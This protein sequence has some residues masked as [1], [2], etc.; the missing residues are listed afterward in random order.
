MEPEDCVIPYKGTYILLLPLSHPFSL[1]LK[2]PAIKQNH[3]ELCFF[4]T[5]EP[6]LQV[7]II[8]NYPVKSSRISPDT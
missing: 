5:M 1:L 2:L 6:Y 4:F 7:H 3:F 8:N